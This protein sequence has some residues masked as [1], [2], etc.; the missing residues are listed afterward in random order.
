MNYLF[1]KAYE[2][3][4]KDLR[5]FS[6]LRRELLLLFTFSVLNNTTHLLAQNNTNHWY[7]G[8]NAGL[9]F[10][11][12]NDPQ[13]LTD[14]AMIAQNPCATMSDKDGSLLFY[15][16][17]TN[18]W[19][20]NHN[21]M[22]NGALVGTLGTGGPI[23]TE[24]NILLNVIII[25]VTDN[26]E[27]YY[28]FTITTADGLRYSIVDMSQGNGL[29]EVTVKN[30][31]LLPDGGIGKLT[32]VHHSDGKSIW[33][34]TTKKNEDDEF[35]SFYCYKINTNG[36]IGS[37]IITNNVF[38]EGLQEG[39][40]K[41]SPDGTKLACA[42]YRPQSLNNHLS[43]FD[44]N[45]ETGVVSYKRN[46]LTS[47]VFFEVVSAFGVEFSNDS[48]FLY[49]TLIRQGMYVENSNEFQPETLRKN[50]LYQYDLSNFN[51]QQNWFSIHEEINA[52]TAAGLQLAKNG[53]IYRA[54]TIKDIQ[55]ISNLGVVNSPELF[56]VEANYVNNAINLG[57]TKS[58]LGLP[59]FI[60]S[61]F[62]TRILAENACLGEGIPM[63]ID[64]YGEITDAIW[65]FG[66]GTTSN[67]VN[68]EHV[69]TTAGNYKVE[70]TITVNNCPITITKDLK[71]YE[72]PNLIEN[73][74]LVQCDVDTDGI[75]LFNLNT[76]KNKITDPLFN[77]ELV[78]FENKADAE[79][80]IQPIVN[81]ESY[82]NTIPNQEVFVRVTNEN[83]CF[84]ITSFFISAVYVDLGNITE[85]YA[86]DSSDLNQNDGS[87][88][89]PLGFKKQDIRQEVNLS[90]STDLKYYPSI[91]DALTEQN[92]ITARFLTSES[93]TIW[94]RA[95]EE[96]LACSG[97]SFFKLIVNSSPKINIENEYLICGN[98]PI[99]LSGDASNDRYEWINIDTGDLISTQREL[100]LS[101]QGSYQHV[102]YKSEN[103]IECSNTFDFKINRTQQP[104][105]NNI[106]VSKI[107][108]NTHLVTVQING[109]GS[110]EFSIDDINYY[111]GQG[112]FSFENIPAGK[113]TV[114]VRDVNQC[115]PT[116]QEDLYI[117]GYPSFFTPNNDGINDFWTV[118]GL[119][120]IELETII[121][122][123]YDRFG[124]MIAYLNKENN[125]RWDGTYNGFVVPQSDYW[126]EAIFENGKINRGHFTLKR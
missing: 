29:G 102:A 8:E 56:E 20:R 17:G 73:Q 28:V 85:M 53:K 104:T 90:L 57:S 19:N 3:Y 125:Y 115:E 119:S 61:Y 5:V 38:Y 32:A 18:I 101:Q 76:I 123:I 98:Q 54:L 13:V 106:G 94:V 111:Q 37:P 7:F 50:L 16:N 35:T 110:Y 124:K 88:V 41:F 105:I 78:F 93:T 84:E 113:Y 6:C 71:I 72:L 15:T 100:S 121:V 24:P 22:V 79:L 116:I 10:D 67:I 69:Y 40:M 1:I 107:S 51:P 120:G 44:F 55:G 70:A 39:Q 114:F 11:F 68:P 77:G 83:G 109:R 89:F 126:Y 86:C 99:V 66:D 91:E 74:E 108:K 23:I 81:S 122:K 118:K 64:T 92:E 97:I 31:T 21:I 27:L 63:E 2:V 58:R 59:T 47:F 95:Q 82:T 52:L 34:M 103:G 12:Q 62:R 87:G 25:P 75:S 49:A 4:L 80:N 26:P 30:R 43:V 60:Q 42:N 36:D 65:D 117:L 48:K 45:S 46:L 33:L 9:L 112:S 96:N 14:G